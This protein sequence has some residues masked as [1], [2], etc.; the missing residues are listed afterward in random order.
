MA[1]YAEIPEE[2]RIAI[3]DQGALIREGRHYNEVEGQ[4]TDQCEY[5]N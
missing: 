2:E 3:A 1:F 4:Y 5:T